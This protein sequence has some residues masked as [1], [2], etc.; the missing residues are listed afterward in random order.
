MSRKR[1]RLSVGT[2]TGCK[3]LALPAGI[4]L[5]AVTALLTGILI[6]Q[7][8]G[9]FASEDFSFGTVLAFIVLVIIICVS[10]YF[11]GVMTWTYLRIART[12]IWLQGSV[13]TERRILLR[14]RVDLRTAP[15]ELR[16]TGNADA[17]ELSLIATD[18]RSGKTLELLIQK[19]QTTLPKPE[20]TALTQAILG[21]DNLARPAGRDHAAA[22]VVADKL[23]ELMQ[24]DT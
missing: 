14:R 23:H 12:K 7:V 11:T 19:G 10:L 24:T 4:A 9:L 17:K 5:A 15:V 8:Q 1:I 16:P 20:L 6:D 21:D 18:Q 13:L 2:P 3:I 22:I